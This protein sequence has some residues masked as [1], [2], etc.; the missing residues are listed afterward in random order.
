MRGFVESNGYI[1]MEAEH[2]SRAVSASAIKWQHL[3]DIGRTGSG[4]TPFP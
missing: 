3:P 4:M 1:S 2:F